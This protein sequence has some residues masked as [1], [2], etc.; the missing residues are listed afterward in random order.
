MDCPKCHGQTRVVYTRDQVK[1]WL[2]RRRE[3]VDCRKRFW[4][5]ETLEILN[6]NEP[7]KTHGRAG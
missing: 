1:P 4:T 3:C 6:P 5:R 7:K 2:R